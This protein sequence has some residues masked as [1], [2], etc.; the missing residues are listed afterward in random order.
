MTTTTKPNGR[1][2]KNEKRRQDEARAE[3]A[4]KAAI[5]AETDANT[6]ASAPTSPA[7]AKGDPDAE[8]AAIR[9]WAHAELNRLVPPTRPCGCGCGREITGRFAPGHDAKLLSRLITGRTAAAKAEA[10]A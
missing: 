3:A 8:K 6:A 7:K 4:A 2:R 1:E 10:A 5:D 9:A